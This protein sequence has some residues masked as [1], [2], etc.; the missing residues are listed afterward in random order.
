MAQGMVTSV[1]ICQQAI[2]SAPTAKRQRSL[3]E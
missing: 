2:E 3:K 1:I